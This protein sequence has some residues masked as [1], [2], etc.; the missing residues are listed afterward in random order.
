MLAKK[1]NGKIVDNYKAIYEVTCGC[2]MWKNV[3]DSEDYFHA[4]PDWDDN[5]GKICFEIHNNDDTILQYDV[6]HDGTIEHILK[7]MRK[8]IKE[9]TNLRKKY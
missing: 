1:L 6:V 3:M 2:V 5:F 8:E 7:I 9:I 4:T